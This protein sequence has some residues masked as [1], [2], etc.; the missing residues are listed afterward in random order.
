MDALKGGEPF[1][2]YFHP[3][4]FFFAVCSEEEGAL[5]HPDFKCKNTDIYMAVADSSGL[6][7]KFGYWCVTNNP[8]TKWP[9]ASISFRPRCD[10]AEVSST[11]LNGGV[12]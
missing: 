5:V 3:T 8:G 6:T 2:H 10:F 12:I 11:M 4:S 9:I 7:F 1:E